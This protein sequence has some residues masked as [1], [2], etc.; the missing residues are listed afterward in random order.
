[1]SSEVIT[2]KAPCIRSKNVYFQVISFQCK[3][4]PFFQRMECYRT[5]TVM[6]PHSYLTEDWAHAH[7]RKWKKTGLFLQRDLSFSLWCLHTHKGNL[8]W[9]QTLILCTQSGGG[10]KT[11]GMDFLRIG[12]LNIYSLELHVFIILL[13]LLMSEI[14]PVFLFPHCYTSRS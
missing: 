2:Y 1:M 12:E 13:A 11:P 4:K 7:I 14:A 8:F 10:V 5:Q 6:W 3:I 9:W